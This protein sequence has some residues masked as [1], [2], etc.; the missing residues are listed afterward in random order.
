MFSFGLET[1][2]VR[3]CESLPM[4]LWMMDEVAFPK[5]FL[6]LSMSKSLSI[7]PMNLTIPSEFWN[8]CNFIDTVKNSI[9]S[10]TEAQCLCCKMYVHFVFLELDMMF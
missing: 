5:G 4:Y 8:C 10:A 3:C 6:E 7:I 1:K 2:Q 9:A